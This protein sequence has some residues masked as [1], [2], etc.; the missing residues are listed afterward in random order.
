MLL[1]V[2]LVSVSVFALPVLAASP[3]N[4]IAYQGRLLN[5]NRVPVSDATASILFELYTASSGGSCVWSNSS[6]TCASATART[7]SLTDGL[8]SENLGDTA[9][10]VPYA[11]I[12]DTIFGNNSTLFLQITIN[13]EALTPRKQIAAAPYALNAQMLDGLDPDTDGSLATAIVAYNSSGNLVVTGNPSGSGV[14]NGSVYINP[15]SGDVA[16]NDVLFGVAVSGSSRLRIDAE[17]DTTIA[18]N[19][20]LDGGAISTI[21]AQGNLFDDTIGGSRV[22]IGGV[23]ADRTN[24]INIATNVTS[25]DVITV[26]N[27]N[28]AST[29]ALTGGT[30]WSVTTAGVA[31]LS[32]MNCTDCVDWS[33]F[34]DSAT[35]DASTTVTLG[36][37]NF[38]F[39]STGIGDFIL[40]NTSGQAFTVTQSGAMTFILNATSN[41]NLTTINNGSGNVVTNLVGTG[42]VVWQDNGTPFFT[43]SDA[44]GVSVTLDST[45]NPN[46][47]VTNQGTGVIAFDLNGGSGSNFGV[48]DNG[49]ATLTIDNNGSYTYSLDN[50]DNPTYSIVNSGSAAVLTNLSGTGDSVWQDN[51]TPFLTLSDT[52][53]YNYTLDPTDNPSY[54]IT[55]AGSQ[56]VLTNLSGTGDSV[57]QDNGSPFLTLSDTGAYDYTLDNTDNPTYTITSQ[58]SNNIITNLM[59]TG[60]VVWQDNGVAFLTIGDAGDYSFTLDATDNPLYTITNAGSSNV[61]TNLSGTGDFIIQDNGSTFVSF[62]DTSTVTVTDNFVVAT[63]SRNGNFANNSTITG[64][65]TGAL[66][67][68]D[69]DSVNIKGTYQA[70]EAV[71]TDG[72]YTALSVNAEINS[73]GDLNT[74]YGALIGAVNNSA[75]AA[76]VEANMYGAY[77]YSTNNA[78]VTIPNAFGIYGQVGAGAGTITTGYGVYGNVSSGGGSLTTGYGGYFQNL[79]EGTDRFGVVG[80]AAGGTNNFA[81][82]FTEGLTLIDDDTNA[83]NSTPSNAAVTGGGDMFVRDSLEGDGS[84]YYGDTTGSDDFIF[85]SASTASTVFLL[86]AN[87]VA[88]NTGFDLKRSNAIATDFDGILMN[89]EQNRTSA[90]SDGVVFNLKNSSGG[91]SAAMYITQDQ[92]A[93][94]TTTP[95]AQALVIDVNES[96]NN[97]E[98]IIIRSD[99]DNSGGVRDTEFRFENDGDAFADGAWTGAGADYAEFFPNADRSLGDYELVCWDPDHANG[100]TRCTA[101]D[102]DVVGVISTNPGFIGNSYSGAETSLENNPNYALVG[103]VGQIET[104]VSADAGAIKI[105]DALTTSSSR[106]GYGAKA[107]G[108]TYII[109]RALEPL[110]SGTGTIKVLVQPMW[111]G[112]EMLTMS[113]EATIF[114][115]DIILGSTQATAADT[116]VDSAGLSFV[117]SAW[118]GSSA[119]DVSLSIR[120][121]VLGNGN[122]RL[123]LQNDDG[124]DVMTFGSTGDLALAGNFYPSDRG[125]LQYGAYVYYD[126]TD[127]GYM[128]TN[129]AGWSSNSSNFAESFASADLLVP[130]DVV[131]FAVDGSGVTR[132]AGETYSDRIAG[133]VSSRSAFVAGSSAGTYPVAVSGR[134]S[135]KVSDENGAIAPGDALTTSS[136]AGFAM[137]ATD[138]GQIIGYALE[139]WASGEGS[140]LAF[141]R[142]QYAH[143]GNSEAPSLLAVGSQDIES[144]NVSGVLSMNGGDIVSVGT[145]SGIGTWEIRENGDIVTNGQLTQVVESLQNTR[146]STYATTSTETIVQ[147][148]GTATL[149]GGMAR[150][151]FEDID[152]NYN[153]IISPDGT[154]RVLV[155]PNGVTG[156]LYVTDRSNVGFIIR[157]ANQGEGVSVDWLVLAYRYDLVPEE[158]GDV[159]ITDSETDVTDGEGIDGIEG[160]SPDDGGIEGGEGVIGPEEEAGGGIEV[161]GEGAADLGEAPPAENS[162]PVD[163]GG[164]GAV[165]EEVPQSPETSPENAP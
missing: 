93:D 29:L 149:H 140:V 113:G 26:G 33:D 32:N 67:N 68:R 156:Q 50:T 103:L 71:G 27:S 65:W 76:A 141:V 165:P 15:A 41:P 134:V 49:V 122:A 6:A 84:L 25:A 58:S 47:Q 52:G 12:G 116:S 92:V 111:Y 110:A 87:A 85:T 117:G 80:R 21:S 56:L 81:A 35:L 154:Y 127:A 95:N 9:A 83:T 94:A 57:W 64:T 158:R 98:V 2:Q 104:Y 120:N 10:G 69:V 97:D 39:N 128:R 89:V 139:S 152:Q 79:S 109:G 70:N 100:V 164:E 161:G 145:L 114:A 82:Y 77:G 36:G 48:I 124:M 60:D 144:L 119:N 59:L 106:A 20:V 51:G 159:D 99:A 55:N 5:S 74:L 3:T 108:G 63:S 150:V 28:A 91:S 133:V 147:L 14:A 130:G 148:S 107:I 61:V 31:T 13:G 46:F 86:N 23:D 54:T 42:D 30:A 22:D 90:G 102:T 11:A 135:T 17:G 62:N 19:F 121:N 34:S 16:A 75:D 125:A 131:E 7:V 44:G 101:G 40:Q 157:D 45:D 129:A 24:T 123:S 143:A 137:K 105:G 136:R 96:A 153:D 53:A 163:G 132:S 151:N 18:G 146:V 37:S 155:T 115:D 73:N 78:A 38:I 138:S 162:D 118:N 112:G 8:F 126:S 66:G 4:I 43:L 142:P 160:I 1:F 72:G 88:T